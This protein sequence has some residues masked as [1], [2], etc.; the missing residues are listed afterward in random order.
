MSFMRGVVE[1]AIKNMSPEERQ[2]AL[3][4]VTQQV[5]SMMSEEERVAALVQIVGHLAR[6]V[7]DERI[8]EVMAAFK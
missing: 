4:S 2:S 8:G 3:Q 1:N 6:S 5:V 7:P